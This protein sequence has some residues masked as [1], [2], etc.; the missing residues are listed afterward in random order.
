MLKLI[1]SFFGNVTSSSCTERFSYRTLFF[2]DMIC[3]TFEQ[4]FTSK[5]GYYTVPK[6]TAFAENVFL[7][8]SH[9][10]SNITIVYLY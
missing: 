3:I 4:T 5:D 2:G 10:N 7:Y 6:V 1:N 8:F 9:F